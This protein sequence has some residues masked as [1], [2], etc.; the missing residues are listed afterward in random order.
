MEE[1]M[2]QPKN[3]DAFYQNITNKIIALLE[4]VSLENYQPPFASLAAQGLPI[5]PFTEKY[6]R[7]I[8]IPCLWFYQQEKN[9]NSNHWATFK[10]WKEKGASVRKGE[11]GSSICFYKTLHVDGEN[12]QGEDVTLKIPMMKLY[13]VFNACQVE[14]YEHS[15]TPPPNE[16]DL[17]KRIALAD[18][19]CANTK[20]DI[21]H[22]NGKGAYYHRIEDYICL[23]ETINFL[24]TAD[25]TATQNYYATLLHELTHWTGAPHR[26]DRDKAKNNTEK[27]K[28]AFEEL[29][30]ELGAAMLCAQLGISQQ[31]RADHA[32][33]IKSWL[34]ALKND[35][36]FVFQASAQ[37][38]R[39]VEYLNDLQP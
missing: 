33:Y 31:P 17:V 22:M 20:A 11:K 2:Y 24:H 9:F 26:L 8:N 14:G 34:Q 5:N 10:Q 3:K 12:K 35:N 16:T 7:G 25:A 30:A 21:R 19:F 29:V 18:E 36:K 13:T 27:F 37:S 38:A 15:E 32:Q 1:T 6:Y 39:A 23:P 4:K 28:Y